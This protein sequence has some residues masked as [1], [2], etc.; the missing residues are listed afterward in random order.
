MTY[1]EHVQLTQDAMALYAQHA[2]DFK[3]R[4]ER[5]PA[6]PIEAAMLQLTSMLVALAEAQVHATLAVATR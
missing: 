5:V 6:L 2:E 1:E 4:S 3:A